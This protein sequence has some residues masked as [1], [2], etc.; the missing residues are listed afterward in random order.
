MPFSTIDSVLGVGLPASRIQHD[1]KFLG[2]P[3]SSCEPYP[4]PKDQILSQEL[5][6][7]V[8]VSGPEVIWK[9]TPLV[10]RKCRAGFV[11]L[12]FFCLVHKL[13]EELGSWLN[14]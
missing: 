12:V 9:N 8:V 7:E 4:C 11:F 6:V 3:Q 5:R 14:W 1:G 2:K 13:N 10:Q